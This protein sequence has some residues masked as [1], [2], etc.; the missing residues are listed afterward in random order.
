[1][2]GLTAKPALE[3]QNLDRMVHWESLSEETGNERESSLARQENSR[4]MPETVLEFGEG[5]IALMDKLMAYMKT[6]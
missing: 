6:K 1:M 3:E 2:T 5:V 4:Q